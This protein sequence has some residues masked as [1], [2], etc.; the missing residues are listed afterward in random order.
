MPTFPYRTEHSAVLY[1]QRMYILGGYSGLAGY[2]LD[3]FYFDLDRPLSE[4]WE[5]VLLETRGEEPAP[6][7]AMSC[8][9]W[10]HFIFI[11]GGWDG[12]DTSNDFYRLNLK[13]NK[14]KRLKSK[15]ERPSPRRS[16]NSFVYNDAMYVLLGFDG[17][18]NCDP[19][20]YRYDFE[21]KRWTVEAV[22]GAPPQ[23]RS[24]AKCVRYQNT[25]AVFG[26]WDRVNHF[27]D[28]HELNLVTKE[29]RQIP[30]DFPSK[31]IGQH[32]AEVHQNRV[33]VFGGFH[34]GKQQSAADLWVYT[35]GHL[36]RTGG[37]A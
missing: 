31:G 7:S 26:G 14:W 4:P 17:E 18:R 29:W 35:L 15:G 12:I 37:E 6:R 8:V 28:W 16:H 23:G 36:G 34:A 25:L 21:A 22:T 32:S 27:E 9:Q 13:T 20:L 11:F 24:R 30:V 3:P 19:Q 2:R 5:P 1:G 10:R 33:Y